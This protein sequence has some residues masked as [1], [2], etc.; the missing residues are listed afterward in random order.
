MGI[1]SGGL[2]VFLVV[3][4]IAG[5][6]FVK[7]K[8]VAKLNVSHEPPRRTHTETPTTGWRGVMAKAATAKGKVGGRVGGVRGPKLTRVA[9]AWHRGG[10]LG[11]A[12]GEQVGAGV[13]GAHLGL[14]RWAGKSPPGGSRLA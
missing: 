5:V 3:A 12:P 2:L 1:C 11:R 7:T 6:E 13:G 9:R 8:R 10:V 14:A 4:N